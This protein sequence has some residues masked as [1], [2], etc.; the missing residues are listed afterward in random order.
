MPGFDET[1]PFGR[2]PGTGM[3]KGKCLTCPQCGFE[4]RP[5]I[6]DTQEMEDTTGGMGDTNGWHGIRPQFL[7]PRRSDEDEEIENKETEKEA[8]DTTFPVIL[9]HNRVRV[10]ELK[11]R[12]IGT[13]EKV[14]LDGS[15]DILF[16][17]DGGEKTV[18]IDV[19]GKNS[20]QKVGLNVGDRLS[21]GFKIKTLHANKDI[22]IFAATIQY[23]DGTEESVV[24]ENVEQ[25]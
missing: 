22:G 1:G 5:R 19:K 23:K 10:P 12:E 20:V 7:S 11:G 24:L 9:K 13:V 6:E 25:I 18:F 14:Y 4:I 8:Q 3:G 21:G 17:S 15:L 2:G 16:P